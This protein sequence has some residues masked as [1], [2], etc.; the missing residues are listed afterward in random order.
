MPRNNILGIRFDMLHGQAHVVLGRRQGLLEVGL[1][2][3]EESPPALAVAAD[4][5]PVGARPLE[6]G[7]LAS[8]DSLFPVSRE[9]R[10]D[11]LLTRVS[12]ARLL[13]DAK[14]SRVETASPAPARSTRKAPHRK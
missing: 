2:D 8:W 7:R 9:P 11:N 6:D 3:P 4:E 10:R 5:A 1:P 13:L 14:T 12:P